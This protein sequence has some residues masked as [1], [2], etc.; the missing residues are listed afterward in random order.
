MA[1]T[2]TSK[3][4][5]TNKDTAKTIKREGL[6]FNEFVKPEEGEI[7]ESHTVAIHRLPADH[8]KIA[9]AADIK[10]AWDQFIIW[11]YTHL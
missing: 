8:E 11:F 9:N 6:V 4:P 7:F 3:G 2:V 10:T 1:Q 5:S